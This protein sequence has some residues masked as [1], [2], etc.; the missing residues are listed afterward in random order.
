MLRFQHQWKRFAAE[1]EC[2]YAKMYKSIKHT[3]IKNFDFVYR[4]SF[5]NSNNKIAKCLAFNCSSNV[6]S[7][8]LINSL[9]DDIQYFV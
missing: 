5:N 8:M 9:D 4:S 6:Q 1:N 3:R 2:D 7:F